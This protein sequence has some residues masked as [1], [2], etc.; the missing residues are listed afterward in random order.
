MTVVNDDT[1]VDCGRRL[2]HTIAAPCSSFSGEWLG[3]QGENPP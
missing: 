3:P 2:R 1:N